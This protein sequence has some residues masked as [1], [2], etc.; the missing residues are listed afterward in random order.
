ME[1]D[2]KVFKFI[3]RGGHC[4][5]NI[6]G[7]YSPRGGEKLNYIR[8]DQDMMSDLRD[9][10]AI[11]LLVILASIFVLVP[12]LNETPVR[13]LLTYPLMFFAPGYVLVTALFPN[14]DELSCIERL[15]LSIGLSIGI[16]IFIGFALN[17]TPWGIR[18]SPI[19]L[20]VTNFTLIFTLVSAWRR[21]EKQNNGSNEIT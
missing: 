11:I 8:P 4:Y 1:D 10:F 6:D 2:S 15:T 18:T 12:P 19:L 13:A 3:L 16:V 21:M 20:L 7:K 9:L 14:D 5:Y 17:Y